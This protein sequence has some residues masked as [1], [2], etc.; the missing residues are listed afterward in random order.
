MDADRHAEIVQRVRAMY[1]GELAMSLAPDFAIH[2][3]ESLPQQP[4][5]YLGPGESSPRAD[6]H[7]RNGCLF[8][9]TTLFSLN[10]AVK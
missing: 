1:A 6:A 8:H 10:Q 5:K 3:P 9:H 7:C 4:L 2:E